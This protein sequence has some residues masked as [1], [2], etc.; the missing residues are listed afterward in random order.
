[1]KF[2]WIYLVIVNVVS[3]I[4]YGVDKAKAKLN[5]WRIPEATLLG[6]SFIGGSLGAFAGMQLFRHK[7]KHIKFKIL[8][9]LFIIFHVV[10]LVV[11]YK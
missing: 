2:L 5:K 6:I 9:P 7:T 1:M 4:M 11:I 3:F 10:I 8:A